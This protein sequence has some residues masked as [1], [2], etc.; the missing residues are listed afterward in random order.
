VSGGHGYGAGV[1]CR[2][3]QL[4]LVA[5]VSL[6]GAG[7]AL[8]VLGGGGGD[9]DG[10][11]CWTT[12]RLWLLRL[13]HAALTAALEAA[14]DW[15]WL[16]D[17]SVQVGPAKVLV[18]LGVR[19]ADLPPPGRCLRPA[20]VRLVALVHGTRWTADDVDRALERAVAA[21]AGGRPPRVVVTDHGGDLAGGVARFRLRHPG[22]A[23]VYDV[24]HR[25]ACLLRRRLAGD[26]RFA[27]FQAAVGRTRCAVQQ[28]AAAALGPPGPK[29][30]ARFMNLGPALK[31]ARGVLR[32]LRDPP[33]SVLRR[34]TRARLAER[35]GWVE[36]FAADVARW[37]RWQAAVDAAVA[38]VGCQGVG[39]G[40]ADLLAARLAEVAGGAAGGGGGDEDDGTARE[41]AAELVRFVRGQEAQARD[42]ERFPGSTEVLESCFGRFKQLERQ[43]SRGGF[44]SLLLA[45]GALLA[46][47][48]SEAVADAMRRSRTADVI[49][50]ARDALGETLVSQRRQ[51][52]A[53]AAA[54]ATG[55]G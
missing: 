1:A 41:L 16:A 22:T 45:F 2:F 42:G 36:G 54:G 35:L 28:T 23:D 15:A 47:V 49:A 39:R 14:D 13:G 44:T 40:T 31:W 34:V 7:R 19:L 4:V 26:A 43:Q 50:W 20:D 52:F 12:G 30:K 11:P 38:L 37:S 8:R 3:L 55:T 51:A 17:H 10:V 5:N 21:R 25:A 18:V 32:V 33:A 9:G 27:A 29:L 53:V 46:D 6:R 24:K 48:T